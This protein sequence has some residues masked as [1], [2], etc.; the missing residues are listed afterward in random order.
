MK[1]TRLFLVLLIFTMALLCL[2]ACDFSFMGG[3]MTPTTAPVTTEGPTTTTDPATTT[4]PVTTTAPITTAP[5]QNPI[6]SVSLSSD[7]TKLIIKYENNVTQNLVTEISPREGYNGAAFLGFDFDTENRVLS[8]SFQENASLNRAEIILS[9]TEAAPKIFYVREMGGKLQYTEDLSSPNWIEFAPSGRVAAVGG[10]PILTALLN[11][12]EY[13]KQE[14]TSMG[15]GVIFTV[16]QE[17]AA[18]E[19]PNSANPRFT[20]GAYLRFRATEWQREGYHYATDARLHGSL[21][22]NFNFSAEYEIE[23]D[24]STDK[25]TGGT[26]FK[27]SGDDIA[28]PNLNKT[29]I[30]GN[31][32]YSCVSTIP[33]STGLTEEDIGSVWQM[34]SQKFVLV[35]VCELS[36]K[37]MNEY[38]W[39]CAFDNSSM[40]SGIMKYVKINQGDVLTHV[41]GATHTNAITATANSTR[42]QLNVATNHLTQ[43]AFLDGKVEIDL[44]QN[45]VYDCEFIDFYEC[46]D[47]I[48]VPAMLNYLME[49]V[50]YNTNESHYDDAIKE[51]YMTMANTYRCHKNGSMVIYEDYTVNHELTMEVFSGISSYRVPTDPAYTYVPGAKPAQTPVAQ[52]LGT[53]IY[54]PREELVDPDYPP[55]TYFQMTSADG[56]F[57]MNTGYYPL[58]GDAVAEKRLSYPLSD[59]SFGW[60]HDTLKMYPRIFYYSDGFLCEPGTTFSVIAYRA[61]SVKTD[62]DMLAVNHYWVGDEIVLSLHTQKVLDGKE[63]TLPDYMNGMTVSVI[64][65][66]DSMTV[67]STVIENGKISFTTTENGYAI[68]QLSPAP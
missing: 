1:T 23:A 55:T 5:P 50:G 60:S 39:F 22:M 41:S 63:I 33:N 21:N 59:K 48:F 34:G 8:L 31:H 4:A 17:T 61:P 10:V 53:G 12:A 51:S 36:S 42:A 54:W 13:G 7:G 30:G 65:K 11:Q 58:Y 24:T 19:T 3:L 16:K 43:R 66:S 2:T 56:A 26:L 29:A 57:A 47:I 32:G 18:T 6:K 52:S 49:N 45:G 38:A 28:P 25:V 40:Q 9:G 67:E 44:T 68:V 14:N 37:D 15:N 62:E 64:E 35:K 27:S 20:N 46:Y